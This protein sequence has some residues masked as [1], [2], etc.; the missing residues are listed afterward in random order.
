MHLE[1]AARHSIAHASDRNS[2]DGEQAVYQNAAELRVELAK[3]AAELEYMQGALAEATAT[4]GLAEGV[5][6]LLGEAAQVKSELQ[7]VKAELSELRSNTARCAC[8]RSV[9]FDMLVHNVTG[10]F[11]RVFLSVK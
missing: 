4:K 3:K 2:D 9:M 6:E 10:L 5:P 11:A 7:L 8:V 1:P